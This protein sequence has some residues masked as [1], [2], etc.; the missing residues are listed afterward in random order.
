MLLLL[1]SGSGV[2]RLSLKCSLSRAERKAGSKSDQLRG[3]AELEK[4]CVHKSQQAQLKLCANCCEVVDP[5]NT[6]ALA[7][8]MLGS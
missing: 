7:T 5:C 8:E 1:P 4:P 2:S 3:C 6:L